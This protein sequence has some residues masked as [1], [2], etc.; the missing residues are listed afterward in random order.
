MAASDRP[1]TAPLGAC[2]SHPAEA[3]PWVGFG[4]RAAAQK[5]HHGAFRIHGVGRR[6]EAV[7]HGECAWVL[8]ELL[9]Q[10]AGVAPV[11]ARLAQQAA[12]V[13]PVIGR[14]L[15]DAFRAVQWVRRVDARVPREMHRAIACALPKPSKDG[16][17]RRQLLVAVAV[18]QEDDLVRL[19]ASVL[20]R[21]DEDGGHLRLTQIALPLAVGEIREEPVGCDR[22]RCV[23][24]GVALRLRV[25]PRVVDGCTDQ[26]AAGLRILRLIHRPRADAVVAVHDQPF[27]FSIAVEVA[28]HVPT[29]AQIPR[30]WY[31]PL[32]IQGQSLLRSWCAVLHFRPPQ[33]R[34]D[35]RADQGQGEDPKQYA[36]GHRQSSV[37]G[38]E[39]G[40]SCG[41]T[42]RRSGCLGN[43][44][45][46]G[47]GL[48]ARTRRAWP[49]LRLGSG[50]GLQQ[51]LGEDLFHPFHQHDG[52]LA[53]HFARDVDQILL[54]ALRD[55]HGLHVH[56]MGG[57]QLLFEPADG[58]HPAAQGDLAG[59][60]EVVT[61]RPSAEGRDQ[62]RGHGDA[63]AGT[64][65]G[66]APLGHVDVQVH[67]VE[68]QFAQAELLRM[69][70]AYVNAA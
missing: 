1:A 11:G 45:R 49:R 54:V 61:D 13:Q 37:F 19:A 51:R 14:D 17:P 40:S 43:A 66:D 41:T 28:R 57:H 68:V 29:D 7:I 58:Q 48:L 46:H 20:G 50:F 16:E 63:G 39:R 69:E 36:L 42:W 55:Q 4:R 44:G 30:Q 53:L 35:E 38:S 31:Q 15:C 67:L 3:G 23:L 9:N 5:C 34:V 32:D 59:H 70:R 12:L 65:L 25:E 8:G 47:R 2:S 26:P 56:A 6:A 22:G 33:V 18:A 52:E 64:I 27:V 10:L 62:R 24:A 21:R 60:G